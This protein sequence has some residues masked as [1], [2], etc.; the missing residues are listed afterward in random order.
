MQ[1][2]VVWSWWSSNVFLQRVQ[3]GLL[4]EEGG[5]FA[6]HAFQELTHYLTGLLQVLLHHR[7]TNRRWNACAYLMVQGML[8]VQQRAQ[9]L[10]WAAARTAVPPIS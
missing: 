9:Q 7:Q 1:G 4:A 10:P 3:Q 5:C 2:C 8:R 6:Q